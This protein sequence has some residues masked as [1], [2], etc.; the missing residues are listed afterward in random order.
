VSARFGWQDRRRELK[1]WNAAKKGWTV[2]TA[3]FDIAVGGSSTVPFTK[4]F[5]VTP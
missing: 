4:V 3:V 2:D 5:S 1:Y